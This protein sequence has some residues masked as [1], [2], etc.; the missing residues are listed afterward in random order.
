MSKS[1]YLEKK[2]LDLVLGAQ[3]FTAPATVYVSLHT[4]DPG[5][6]AGTNEVS[7]NAYARVAVTNNLTNWPAAS[8]TS[9]TSKSNGTEIL[10]PTPTG[11]WGTVSHFA[12]Y[13]AASAGNMLYKGALSAAQTIASGNTVK[14]A[15]AA[16]NVQED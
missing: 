2:V 10:F 12:V 11:S 4:A 5:E 16:L 8:G 1:D 13:D 9:P 6:A 14:F 7:G 15:V 3:A